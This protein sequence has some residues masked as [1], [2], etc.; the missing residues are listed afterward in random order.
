MH[1][2]SSHLT[3]CCLLGDGLELGVK[4]LCVLIHCKHAGAFAQGSR[5]NDEIQPAEVT[6][7]GSNGAAVTSEPMA[8]SASGSQPP[9]RR[10]V[11]EKDEGK[12][13]FVCCG[14]GG[15]KAGSRA[16]RKK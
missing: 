5:L 7:N 4:P 12:A 13:R 10:V 9:P 11:Q 8:A 16:N 3:G 6:G 14:F 2:A 15:K 1:A